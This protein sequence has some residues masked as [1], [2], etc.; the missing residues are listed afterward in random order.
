MTGCA[1]TTS[2]LSR[3]RG[4]RFR[5]VGWNDERPRLKSTELCPLVEPRLLAGDVPPQEDDVRGEERNEDVDRRQPDR[6][7]DRCPVRRG[8]QEAVPCVELGAEQVG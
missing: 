1:M 8:S 2:P 6:T 5:P 3:V 7:H 4:R